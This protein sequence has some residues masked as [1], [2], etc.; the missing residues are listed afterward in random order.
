MAIRLSLIKCGSLPVSDIFILDE[1]TATLDSY[2]EHYI[3]SALKTILKQRTCFIIAHRLSTVQHAHRIYVM[4]A[5]RIVEQGNFQELMEQS[6][7]FKTMYQ[8]A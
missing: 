2:T 8:S 4:E 5:G 6:S 7:R 3:Q 1:A